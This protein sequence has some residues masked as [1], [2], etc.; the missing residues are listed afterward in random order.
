LLITLL[1]SCRVMSKGVEDYTLTSIL[2]HAKTQNFKRVIVQFH[3]GPKNNQMKTILENNCFTLLTSDD[4]SQ[5]Y[6]LDLTTQQIKPYQNW[7][8]TTS[9]RPH[10]NTVAA[11]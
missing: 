1:F 10:H 9:C 3:Q 11:V 7:F 6:C 8:N 4:Q 5:T 2:N